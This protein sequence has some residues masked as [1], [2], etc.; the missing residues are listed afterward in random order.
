MQ[1]AA[2]AR[3]IR[4][5]S[6]VVWS[7]VA[8]GLTLISVLIGSRI[9]F[10]GAPLRFTPAAAQAIGLALHELATNAGKYGALSNGAGHVRIA[11][12]C[13]NATFR[14]AW[15]ERGGPPVQP[16]SR[17][18]FGSTVLDKLARMTVYGNVDLDYAPEGF[19]WALTCPADKALEAGRAR[20]PYMHRSGAVTA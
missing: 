8:A 16:P 4:L 12:R 6:P 17:C 2:S 18:G 14:F 9:T 1:A 10:E 3:S 20:E 11:W 7:L 5:P 13:E 15:R 19:S